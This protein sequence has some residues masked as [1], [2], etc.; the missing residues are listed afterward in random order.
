LAIE[1]LNRLQNISY[2]LVADADT[3]AVESIFRD[4]DEAWV[5][6]MDGFLWLQGGHEFVWLSERTGWRQA[7]RVSREG[8]IRSITHGA[9]DVISLSGIDEKAGWLYFIASPENGTQKY[10]YRARLDGSGEAERVTPPDA[11]GTH[12]YDISPDGRWAFHTYSS[13]DSPPKS[14]LVGLTTHNSVRTLVDNSALEATAA[15]LLA[16]ARHQFFRLDIGDGVTVDGSMLKPASFDPGK[17]IPYSSMST[18]SLSCKWFWMIGVPGSRSVISGMPGIS[19]LTGPSRLRAMS[20]SVSI[21][22]VRQHRR[23]APG[24]RSYTARSTLSS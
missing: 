11:P 24:A 4:Q 19:C 3:G 1:H 5:D 16:G 6:Y 14:D 7:V 8:G 13:A 21:P 20:S 2:V 17:N 12:S 23:G 18:A 15:P 9:F 10:L 22:V